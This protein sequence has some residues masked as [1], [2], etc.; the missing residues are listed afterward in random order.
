MFNVQFTWQG[1]GPGISLQVNG[2]K[3]RNQTGGAV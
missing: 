3:K 1:S 2:Q